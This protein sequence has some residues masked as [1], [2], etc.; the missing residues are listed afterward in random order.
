[1]DRAAFEAEE[2]RGLAQRYGGRR[3][4]TADGIG[5]YRFS[6]L[7]WCCPH[8]DSDTMQPPER[9]GEPW[10]CSRGCAPITPEPPLIPCPA[11]LPGHYGQR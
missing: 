3:E 7:C 10:K 2:I 1:M 9:E 4:Y 5:V 11:G 6:P 8:W